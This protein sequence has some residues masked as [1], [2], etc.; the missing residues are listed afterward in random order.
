[1]A[2]DICIFCGQKPGAFQSISIDC[3]GVPQ[4]ACKAC[5]KE[6]K[7][8]TELELC[9]RALIR[10]MAE[11]PERI[12]ARIELINEAENHRPKCLQ[13]GEKLTFTHMQE[14]DNSPM[15]NDIFKDSFKIQPA[16]CKACGRYEFYNPIT[17]RK[18]KHLAYLI[19]KD[20]EN[21]ISYL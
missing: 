8:L 3:G 12:Q 14:L 17:V 5:E 6:L 10:G 13:C 20:T 16:L 2:D 9:Q 1:M 21:Y 15:R 7:D 11:K 19:K 4:N 18:N